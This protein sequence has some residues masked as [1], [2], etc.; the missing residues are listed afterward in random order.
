MSCCGSRRAAYHSAPAPSGRSAAA[1]FRSVAATEFEYIG[2]AQLT[3]TGPV[4]GVVYR[5]QAH[6]HRV[7]VHGTDA[8]SLRSIPLLRAVR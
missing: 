6:G 5:F 7:Q 4:T 1:S 8:A 2:H 3:V